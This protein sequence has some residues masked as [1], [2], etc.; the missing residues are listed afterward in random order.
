[1]A[2]KQKPEQMLLRVVRV[3]EIL[4]TVDASLSKQKATDRN[5]TSIRQKTQH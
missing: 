2:K 5:A 1:M 3:A 4:A